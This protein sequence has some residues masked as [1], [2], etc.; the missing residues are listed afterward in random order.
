MQ[1]SI[2]TTSGL[3]RRLLVAVPA[4]RIDDEVNVRLQKASKNVRI[5]GFR[6]GKVPMKVIRQRYGAGV[7]QEVAGEVMSQSFYEAITKQELKPASQ[8][9]IEPKTIEEG[10]DLEFVAT[11]EIFPEIE[12]QDY[13]G[14]A[15][16]KPVAEV[17]DADVNKM[18]EQFQTQQATWD[19]VDRAAKQGDRVNIDY[20]GT[21]D[22]D[23]F[24][25]GTAS[26]SDLELGSNRMIPGFE[27]GIIGMVKGE[28]KV[29]ALS[30][31]EEYH[32]DELKG[33]AVE[34]KVTLNT[35]SERVL[36]PLDEAFFEKYGVK[37]G[38]ES[39]FREEIK[40][41]MSR[42]LENATKNRVKTQVMDQLLESHADLQ[43]PTAL[44]SQEITALRKQSLQQFGDLPNSENIDF[45]SILPDDMFKEQA[46]RRVRLGLILNA[47]ITQKEMKADADKVKETIEELAS[48]YEKPEEVVNWY[49]SNKQ[50][51]DGVESMVLENTVVEQILDASVVSEKACS[52]EEAMTPPA[53]AADPA[54]E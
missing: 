26:G 24:D 47:Y 32:S 44:I 42:E 43:M 48:S 1:V 33:A 21:K 49:Y 38:G 53:P 6:P 36:P 50:Q 35:V 17:L 37:E 14:F 31:P 15:V 12:L 3:E 54:P 28:E 4:Q 10:R 20:I 22:G 39:A 7:R 51:L 18:I 13:A 45:A 5:D 11:F 41:N 27:D 30:F 46:E 23:T 9:K 29:L 40:G 34:F 52:Y 8:P 2:E 25:G 19:D 16:E